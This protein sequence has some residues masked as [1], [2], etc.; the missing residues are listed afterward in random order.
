MGRFSFFHNKLSA[1]FPPL[2][3]T[4]TREKRVKKTR[5]RVVIGKA[6]AFSPKCPLC[7]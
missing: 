2:K 3:S 6:E 4:I 1:Q 7:S 5:F